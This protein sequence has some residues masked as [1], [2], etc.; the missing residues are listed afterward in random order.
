M[1]ISVQKEINFAIESSING[2][3][4]SGVALLRAAKGFVASMP[5][6][7]QRRGV[8]VIE[9]ALKQVAFT[10]TQNAGVKN[11]VVVGRFIFRLQRSERH[12]W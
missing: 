6:F 7:G 8:D 4:H 3:P 11:A 10:I 9:T 2:L 1:T 12:V 5:N